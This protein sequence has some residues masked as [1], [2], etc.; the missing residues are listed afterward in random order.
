MY[1]SQI[2]NQLY[3][4][5]LTFNYQLDNIIEL[6]LLF[7][8]KDMK[9]IL[10]VKFGVICVL[11]LTSCKNGNEGADPVD[12]EQIYTPSYTSLEDGFNVK[13]SMSS[14]GHMGI[15]VEH[16]CFAFTDYMA[17]YSP[18]GNLEMIVAGASEACAV[19]GWKI[20][21]GNDGYVNE[22]CEVTHTDYGYQSEISSS[23]FLSN[24][25]LADNL[26]HL[27]NSKIQEGTKIVIERNADGN[28]EKVGNLEVPYDYCAHYFISEWGP[29]WESDVSGGRLEFFT[30]MERKDTEGS[31]V[32]Y[33]YVEDKLIA[34]LAYWNG[35]FIK[36]RTYNKDGAMVSK[37]DNRDI[38]IM[39]ET[40]YDFDVTPKWYIDE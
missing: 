6:T 19:S 4:V 30:L 21:Y 24:S 12:G 1:S 36:A 17:L 32:N 39:V 22:V 20:S 10:L 37:Y 7:K 26:I 31:Y 29:F 2:I 11:L 3:F 27:Q 15:L 8:T 38:D 9:A 25:S 18:Q 13:E 23:I 5:E 28:V 35:T 34:E 40:Y 33:L 14:D 16:Q